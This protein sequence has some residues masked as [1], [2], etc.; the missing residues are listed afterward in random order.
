MEKWFDSPKSK[1]SVLY[2]VD[3][4][5]KFFIA[6]DLPRHLETLIH[7]LRL[8]VAYTNSFL[9]KIHRSNSPECHCGQAEENVRHILLEC[10]KY[11]NEREKLKKKLASLDR[12]PLTLKKLLGPWPEMHLQKKANIFLTDFLVETGLDKRL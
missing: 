8:E 6:T 7:R 4:H 5:R 1:E 10:V 11:A 3:P 12:R 9:H 2:E